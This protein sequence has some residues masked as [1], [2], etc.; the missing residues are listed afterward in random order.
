MTE[1][2][3]AVMENQSRKSRQADE[4]FERLVERMGEALNLERGVKFSEPE[5]VP[6]WL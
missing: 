2:D 4:M 6:A 1:G 3:R 5:E